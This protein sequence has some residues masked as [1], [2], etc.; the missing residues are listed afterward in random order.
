MPTISG[1]P[2]TGPFFMRT[3]STLRWLTLLILAGLS[4]ASAAHAATELVIDADAQLAY[5]RSLLDQGEYDAA[6]AEFDRFIHFFPEDDRVPRA[7]FDAAMAHYDAGRPEAAI[8]GF[9]RLSEHFTGDRLQTEAFFM[10]SQCHARQGNYGQAILDL[11]SLA[12]LSDDPDV[13]DRAR[14]EMGWRYVDQAD[15]PKAREA[16]GS[17]SEAQRM[18][19]RIPALSDSLAGSDSIPRRDPTT[20]GVLSVIPG[21]GQLYCGRYQDAL[22]A[23]LINTGLIWASWEAFDNDQPAL[24]SVLAFVEFGFYAG[25]IYSAV[26]SA[27]KF[28]RD[29]AAEFRDRLYRQRQVWLS[30][31]PR[32]GGAVMLLAVDF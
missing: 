30:V 6:I 1:T 5:A 21:A 10:L 22:A 20:A 11:H 29:R 28:N 26:S 25:N 3:L 18:R 13:I 19:L 4:L 31:A 9:R 8:A 14:Y 16:F 32:N 7:R 15:W 12:A 24:G 27:H 17:V 2:E 23:L